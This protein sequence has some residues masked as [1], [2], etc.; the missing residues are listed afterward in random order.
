MKNAA[1]VWDT[2]YVT[3]DILSSLK[4]NAPTHY[5]HPK[6]IQIPSNHWF[7][8]IFQC[9][10]GNCVPFGKTDCCRASFQ[11]AQDIICK[12][13]WDSHTTLKTNQV[14]N[15][16]KKWIFAKYGFCNNFGENAVIFVTNFREEIPILIRRA[17]FDNIDLG[18]YKRVFFK[19]VVFFLS[20]IYRPW[21][22]SA[23]H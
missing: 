20:H 18:S 23:L 10:G 15:F 13:Y 7:S 17:H 2:P 4:R 6:G 8:T 12:I 22:L 5:V 11:R 16:W 14:M 3:H 21:L 1:D 9:F 19:V